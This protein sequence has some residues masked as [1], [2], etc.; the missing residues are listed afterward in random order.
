MDEIPSALIRILAFIRKELFEIIRQPRLLFTLVTGPF[1]IL[2]IFGIGYCNIPRELRTL[3]VVSQDSAL[4]DRVEQYATT[5]GLQLIF[6][7]VIDD[8]IF[9]RGSPVDLSLLGRLA[10]I[11]LG[12]GFIAWLLLR[13][14][15]SRNQ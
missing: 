9:F 13:R 3:F 11:G 1:L 12:L 15:T 7:G 8:H 4:R 14:I 2:L 10:A 5:L 6:A